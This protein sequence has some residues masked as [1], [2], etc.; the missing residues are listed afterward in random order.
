[1]KQITQIFLEGESPTLKSVQKIPD[2]KELCNTETRQMICIVIQLTG[3]YIT[4]NST[5]RHF[6]NRL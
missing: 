6:S 5:V 4:Q 1:M 3:F 2:N